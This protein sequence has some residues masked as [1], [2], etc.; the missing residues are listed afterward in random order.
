MHLPLHPADEIAELGADGGGVGNPAAHVLRRNRLPFTTAVN[1]RA[2]ATPPEPVLFSTTNPS[3]KP[4][5]I[6]DPLTVS[7]GAPIQAAQH[8]SLGE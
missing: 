8:R 7:R 5:T 3:I 4:L 1:P 6:G 2:W